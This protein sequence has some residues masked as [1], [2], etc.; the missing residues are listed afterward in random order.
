MTCYK[1]RILCS[2]PDCPGAFEDWFVV[3]VK[4]NKRLEIYLDCV[5]RGGRSLM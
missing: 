1:N 5:N 3:L 2:P 4:L